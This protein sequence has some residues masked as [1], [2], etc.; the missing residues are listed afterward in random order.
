MAARR[1]LAFKRVGPDIKEF[2]QILSESVI[3]RMFH[4][5]FAIPRSFPGDFEDVPDK[6]L[7]TVRH[8]HDPVGEEQS[9]IYVVGDHQSRNMVSGPQIHEDTLEFIPG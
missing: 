3:I 5:G 1:V 2:D 9:L 4:D 7:R 8:H 6:G